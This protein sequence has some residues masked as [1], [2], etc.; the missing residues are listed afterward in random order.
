M[1][2]ITTCALTDWQPPFWGGFA[3]STYAV[4]TPESVMFRYTFMRLYCTHKVGTKDRILQSANIRVPLRLATRRDPGRPSW[5]HC[6]TEWRMQGAHCALHKA[7]I[8]I[9]AERYE[10]PFYRQSRTQIAIERRKNDA[11]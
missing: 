10:T 7:G 6:G 4:G 9:Q 11:K 8:T 5:L 2:A 3:L 1:S